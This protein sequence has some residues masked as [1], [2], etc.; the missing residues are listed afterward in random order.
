MSR[1]RWL[2][3]ISLAKKHKYSKL[4][5]KKHNADT[6]DVAAKVGDGKE[7]AMRVLEGDLT[8]IQRFP[9]PHFK[10]TKYVLYHLLYF[11]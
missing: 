2:E 5:E 3:E 10:H 9:E 1:V 4:A 11:S 8:D 7:A 6:R